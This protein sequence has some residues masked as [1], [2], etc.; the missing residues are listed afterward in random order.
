MKFA[1][2]AILLICTMIVFWPIWNGRFYLTGDMRDVTIPIESFF[3]QE[4]LAGRLPAWMPDA[5]FGFPIIAAAQIGFFYPPSLIVRFLPIFIY[6]PLL[7]VLHTALAAIGTYSFARRLG[8]SQSASILTAACVT[9][10]AFV[11]QHITHLN[12]YLALA[13]LPWQLLAVKKITQKP[14]AA[15]REALPSGAIGVMGLVIGI[16][17]LIGQLQIPA[18]MAGFSLLY[19]LILASQKISL[20]TTLTHIM[21]ISLLGAAVASA[22][23]L[24]TLELVKYSS[25]GADGDFDIIR[26]NQHSYPIYH[27]PTLVFPRFFGQ[28]NTYWGKRLEIE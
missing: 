2:S 9:L 5:A 16:P 3:R 15:P 10:G 8:Q 24:P 21:L 27:L 22:Q 1:T 20:R 12:I 26:A 18:L 11:W 17:F 4:Q 25:R 6:V 28:D 7:V 13:W 14:M 23:V 19:Y